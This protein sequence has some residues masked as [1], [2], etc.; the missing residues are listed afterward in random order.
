LLLLGWHY[1]ISCASKDTQTELGTSETLLALLKLWDDSEVEM[2]FEKHAE[3]GQTSALLAGH[4]LRDALRELGVVRGA[5]G[6]QRW[7]SLDDFKQ[8]ARQPSETEL[9]MQM[10]P[11]ASLLACSFGKMTLEEL[12]DISKDGVSAGF[13]AFS[14][15][16]KAMFEQR[17]MKLKNL[18]EKALPSD[19]S[20][21]GGVLAGGTV[22]DFHSGL[23]DRLG[24]LYKH[25]LS[26]RFS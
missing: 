6:G 22:D 7:Y 14:E 18:K 1:Q 25:I 23:A 20:K 15:C 16:V 17:L 11:M 3:K 12:K 13:L 10:I 2:V 8:I 26:Y 5:Q 21:F 9:W 4:K 24:G 19:D